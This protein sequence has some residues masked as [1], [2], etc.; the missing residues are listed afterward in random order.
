M[1]CLKIGVARKKLYFC[2]LMITNRK[3]IISLTKE[4]P[5][6]KF[7]ISSF[8]ALLIMLA[9]PLAGVFAASVTSQTQKHNCAVQLSPLRAGQ[10]SSDVVSNKCFAT[11]SQAVAFAT[12]EAVHLSAAATPK[13]L[14]AAQIRLLGLR[15]QVTLLIGILYQNYSEGGDSLTVYTNSSGTPCNSIADYGISNLATYSFAN[16]VSSIEQEQ[17]NCNY[18]TL[19]SSTGYTGT[20]SEC[21]SGGPNLDVTAMNDL[22]VSVIWGKLDPSGGPYSPK[23][24]C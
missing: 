2:R 6:K 17:N 11:F 4:G 24:G 21:Y 23:T 13:D 1:N 20:S 9:V 7:L 8:A 12:H 5:L 18:T 15:P 10:K 16:E 19:Y 14:T 3:M 22:A